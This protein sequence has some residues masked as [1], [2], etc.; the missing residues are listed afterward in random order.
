MSFVSVINESPYLHTITLQQRLTLN[1][2]PTRFFFLFPFFSNVKMGFRHTY[3]ER[4]GVDEVAFFCRHD[5]NENVLDL[6]KR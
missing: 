2:L 6:K 1:F 3:L 5:S 4:C